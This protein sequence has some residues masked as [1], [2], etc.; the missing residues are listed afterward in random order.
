MPDAV[1]H[2][3]VKAGIGEGVQFACAGWATIR[4]AKSSFRFDVH[5][6]LSGVGISARPRAVLGAIAIKAS[7]V[8]DRSR[9]TLCGRPD[10]RASGI[11][12]YVF[13]HQV[14]ADLKASGLT[15]G[16]ISAPLGHSVDTTKGV[17]GA[18]Q[19]AGTAGGFSREL[20]QQV[21]SA[22]NEGGA[23]SVQ[24]RLRQ[25][26]RSLEL[27]QRYRKRPEPSNLP[28][29]VQSSDRCRCKCVRCMSSR[30]FVTSALSPL[31]PGL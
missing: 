5:R 23:A 2:A 31:L 16:N 6:T 29:Q 14:A 28:G 24:T 20:T 9:S 17:Y 21:P 4:I 18:A 1:Q 26:K 30:N 8:V 7:G 22:K 11:S 13:R 27:T 12:D 10:A 19:S 3:S 15:E 25:R